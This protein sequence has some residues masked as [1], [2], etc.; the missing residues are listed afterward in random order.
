M[1]KK[2]VIEEWKKIISEFQ[3]SKK[4][5]PAWCNENN[6]Q[7]SKMRYWIKKLKKAA[8]QQETQWIPVT[9]KLEN[10]E[11]KSKPKIV[12]KAGSYNIEIPDGFS[13]ETLAELLRVIK[14]NV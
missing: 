4:T 5:A 9:G 8:K 13:Q 2:M 3:S 6:V 11:T 7:L 14:V 12:I 10:I 1:T